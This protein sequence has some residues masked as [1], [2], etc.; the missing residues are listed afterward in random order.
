VTTPSHPP[1]LTPSRPYEP[2]LPVAAEA[3]RRGARREAAEP[4]PYD[5]QALTAALERILGD[6]ARRHG[7]EA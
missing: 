7:I 1:L 2:T 3:L 4:V 5:T 6:E